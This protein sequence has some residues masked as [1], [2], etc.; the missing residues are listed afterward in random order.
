[1]LKVWE[2]HCIANS[3][4]WQVLCSYNV[5]VS[6]EYVRC[7]A[8]SRVKTGYF[9]LNNVVV[10]VLQCQCTIPVW[11]FHICTCTKIFKKRH[12]V[13]CA[14][15][16]STEKVDVFFSLLISMLLVDMTNAERFFVFLQQDW[17]WQHGESIESACAILFI[18]FYISGTIS[19]N[20][21]IPLH[22]LFDQLHR[23]K[24]YLPKRKIPSSWLHI[25]NLCFPALPSP[26]FNFKWQKSPFFIC[27]RL[28]TNLFPMKHNWLF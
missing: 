7:N 27:P 8:L 19:L 6:F 9:E 28:K 10:R 18:N 16:V 13:I 20:W 1:M 17:F 14:Q 21:T 15:N 25:L 12:D 5:D 11:T 24:G 26:A 2:Q 22:S 23:F 4:R 3:I